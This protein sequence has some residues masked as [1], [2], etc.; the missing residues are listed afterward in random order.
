MA[1]DE[2]PVCDVCGGAGGDWIEHGDPENGQEA[3]REVWVPCPPCDGI[4][5]RH[6]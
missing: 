1:D 3:A 2:P 4:G 5:R 6:R